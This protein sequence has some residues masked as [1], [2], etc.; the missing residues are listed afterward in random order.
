MTSFGESTRRMPAAS[1]AAPTA[2][3]SERSAPVW[4][5][6]AAVPASERPASRR[7]TGLPRSAASAAATR[8]CPTVAEVLAVHRD[9]PRRLVQGEIGDH[10]GELEIGLVAE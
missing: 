8:E 3:V 10:L 9:Q 4:D 1:Q 7:R 6:A 5:R 2:R